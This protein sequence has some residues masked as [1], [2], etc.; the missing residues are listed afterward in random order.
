MI[1][2]TDR[3]APFCVTWDPNKISLLDSC[4]G[5]SA[6]FGSLQN[7]EK[8]LWRVVDAVLLDFFFGDLKKKDILRYTNKAS[9]LDC[10]NGFVEII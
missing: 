5:T 3:R 9:Y 8:S 4:W 6:N 1:P 7:S 2:V 10:R